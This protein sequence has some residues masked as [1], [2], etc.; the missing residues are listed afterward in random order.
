MLNKDY[1]QEITELIEELTSNS[2]EYQP[3]PEEVVAFL[4]CTVAIEAIKEEADRKIYT[5]L[6]EH[7]LMDIMGV[8]MPVS[9]VAKSSCA[10]EW[11]G[12]PIDY[13]AVKDTITYL[14][15]ED[16]FYYL[17]NHDG[18]GKRSRLFL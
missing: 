13:E 8:V 2:L 12:T 3:T 11:C 17:C 9:A 5:C 18:C 14:P 4:K 16:R 1:T 15:D 6:A 10:C 7:G